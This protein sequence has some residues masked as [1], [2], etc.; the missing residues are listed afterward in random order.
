MRK[1]VKASFTRASLM[2]DRY[3]VQELACNTVRELHARHHRDCHTTRQLG[4][5][6]AMLKEKPHIPF[7]Y[8]NGDTTKDLFVRS[9]YLPFKSTKK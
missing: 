7:R 4:L 3:H 8:A 6:E 1:I 9:R 2:T 5:E